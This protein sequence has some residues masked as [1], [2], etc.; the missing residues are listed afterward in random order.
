MN[1]SKDWT[2]NIRH[3]EPSVAISHSDS[4]T[5][6]REGARE[7]TSQAG[8]GL[9]VEGCGV[10]GRQKQ[11][12]VVTRDQN[13]SR[14]GVLCPPQSQI[15]LIRESAAVGPCI[16]PIGGLAVASIIAD[17][18]GR[19]ITVAVNKRYNTGGTSSRATLHRE[20]KLENFTLIRSIF[21][22]TVV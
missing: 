17:N 21:K 9:H 13:L 1:S 10:I 4:I 20:G 12:T 2:E 8:H 14:L 22:R 5:S 3:V 16:A 7:S 11:A 6:R 19:C 18:K 15:L